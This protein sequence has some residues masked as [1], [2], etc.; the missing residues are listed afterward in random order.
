[1]ERS[2]EFNRYMAHIGSVVGRSE[3]RE[4]LKGYCQGLML[5]LRGSSKVRRNLSQALDFRPD[6]RNRDAAVFSGAE[7]AQPLMSV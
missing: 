4:L 1:M 6:G 3:R 2:E 7:C 5:P